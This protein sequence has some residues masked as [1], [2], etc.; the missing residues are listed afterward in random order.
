MEKEKRKSK[1]KMQVKGNEKEDE[2]R[3]PTVHIILKM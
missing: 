1:E 2:K 3:G